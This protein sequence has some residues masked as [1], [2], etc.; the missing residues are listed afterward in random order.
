MLIY[1][2]ENP[3]KGVPY[4]FKLSVKF[5]S[6]YTMDFNEPNIYDIYCFW[7]NGLAIVCTDFGKICLNHQCH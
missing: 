6:D 3:A 5:G 1:Q 7:V 4:H 2:N